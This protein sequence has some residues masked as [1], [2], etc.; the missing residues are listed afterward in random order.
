MK[1]NQQ[2]WPIRID[3]G[4]YWPKKGFEIFQNLQIV[5]VNVAEDADL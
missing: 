4:S 3:E 1:D 5:S 2:R